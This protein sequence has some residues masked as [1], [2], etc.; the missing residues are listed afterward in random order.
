[1]YSCLIKIGMGILV[2]IVLKDLRLD[3]LLFT[4]EITLFVIKSN[5]SIVNSKSSNRKSLSPSLKDFKTFCLP[6]I[7]YSDNSRLKE[8]E[9]L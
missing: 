8:S 2:L 4:I 7:S 9:L 3:D 6:A 5:S 1:M